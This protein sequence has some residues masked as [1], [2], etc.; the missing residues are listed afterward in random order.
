VAVKLKFGNN[1]KNTGN[2]NLSYCVGEHLTATL[3]VVFKCKAQGSGG[4]DAM[5][6]VKNGKAQIT[7]FEMCL[8]KPRTGP[9]QTPILL[10]SQNWRCNHKGS[11]VLHFKFSWNRMSCIIHWMA[12][13]PT[14]SIIRYNELGPPFCIK[15][16]KGFAWFSC[17]FSWSLYSWHVYLYSR[18]NPYT[19]F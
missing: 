7:Y 17:L 1:I 4:R 12:N 19:S 10:V 15:V 6:K 11:L 8:L 9:D 3:I 18:V 2:L 5:T 14:F 13:Q 16:C